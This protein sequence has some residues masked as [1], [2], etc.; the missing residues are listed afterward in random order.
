[1]KKTF[2]KTKPVL[3]QNGIK[4]SVLKPISNLKNRFKNYQKVFSK[5]NGFYNFNTGCYGNRCITLIF[6]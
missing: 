2:F 3:N 4:N 5:R 1:M 6:I